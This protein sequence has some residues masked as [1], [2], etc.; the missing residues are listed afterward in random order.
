VFLNH[1]RYRHI[2]FEKP[3]VG[4]ENFLGNCNKSVLLIGIQ[5]PLYLIRDKLSHIN[6]GFYHGRLFWMP[7]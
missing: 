5:N 6:F 3:A 1:L 2:A 7:Q 4:T